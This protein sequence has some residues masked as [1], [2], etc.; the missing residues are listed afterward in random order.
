M[1]LVEQNYYLYIMLGREDTRLNKL[2]SAL[3][4]SV[5]RGKV[6]K[7][8]EF[9][10]DKSIWWIKQRWTPRKRIHQPSGMTSVEKTQ[11][12]E[13]SSK[14]SR[15]PLWLSR[16]MTAHGS[17][18]RLYIRLLQR[19]RGRWSGSFCTS[20]LG[21]C[22]NFHGMIRDWSNNNVLWQSIGSKLHPTSKHSLAE[23][24]PE[25]RLVPSLTIWL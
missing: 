24:T 11:P 4:L 22:Q 14:C 12:Q 19:D 25:P 17:L 2:Y 21:R 20:W 10:E 13:S 15:Q 6:M 16:S 3:E 1:S 8:D 23:R 18:S 7:M 5:S 9:L